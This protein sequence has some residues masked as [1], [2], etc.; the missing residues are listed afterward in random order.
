MKRKNLRHLRKKE[1]VLLLA[2]KELE[3]QTLREILKENF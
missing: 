3:I 1:R 2:E